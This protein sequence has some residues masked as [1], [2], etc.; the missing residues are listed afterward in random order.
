MSPLL[1][2][3]MSVYY[4]CISLLVICD[5][6]FYIMLSLMPRTVIQLFIFS[7]P[8]NFVMVRVTMDPETIIHGGNAPYLENQRGL[9]KW[10]LITR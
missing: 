8:K 7:R 6:L 9:L 2:H 10:I 3:P 4:L 1:L 5:Q